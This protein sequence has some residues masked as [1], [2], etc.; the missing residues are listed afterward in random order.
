MHCLSAK[1]TALA[2]GHHAARAGGHLQGAGVPASPQ[3][4]HH[5]QGPQIR[6]PA[7]GRDL[8]RENMRL[9][10]GQT[11]GLQHRCVNVEEVSVVVL[12]YLLLYCTEFVHSNMYTVYFILL[13]L[14]QC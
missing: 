10:A 4:A 8:Q 5:P 11:E 1:R 14:V 2:G 6:Q 3:P 7:A 12:H 9:R 13:L